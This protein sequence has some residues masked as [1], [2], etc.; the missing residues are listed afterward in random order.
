LRNLAVGGI[1]FA[2]AFSCAPT[3][4]Q[5][6]PARLS[7]CETKGCGGD[8]RFSGRTGTAHWPN[9]V[10]AELS[11]ERFDQDQVI[12]R[13]RD[14]SSS[15]LGVTAVYT[16]TIHGQRIEGDVT[17][18]WPGHWATPVIVQW[19]ATIEDSSEPAPATA[20]EANALALRTTTPARGPLPNLNGI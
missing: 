4:S 7:E 1:L 19:Y 9:G 14:T 12:I 13:R 17:Y 15:T 3:L 6:I 16:G 18:S 8:W 2:L 11:I 20:T 10:E 5:S